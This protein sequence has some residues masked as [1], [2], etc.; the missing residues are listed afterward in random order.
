M[1]FYQVKTLYIEVTHACNQHCRHCYLDGGIHR[2]IAEMSFEQIK[3]LLYQFKIQGGSYII[4]TGGEPLART[5]IFD[6]LDYIEELAIPFTFASNALALSDARLNKLSTYACLK[7]FFTSILGSDP[8]KHQSITGKDS[9][10]KVIHALVY[11]EKKNI[12][13]YVQVTLANEYINDMDEIAETLLKYHDCTVKFTPIASLGV[14]SEESKAMNQELVVPKENFLLFHHRVT[15]L[16]SKYPDR[17]DNGNLLNYQQISETI[18]EYKNDLLYSLRYQ[19]IAVRPNGDISFSC[20]MMNPY[21]FG[22]AY[23]NIRIPID[24][25]LLDYI[26]CLRNAESAAL[27]DAE[28]AVIEFDVVVDQY[29]LEQTL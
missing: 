3:N 8:A 13:V 7:T 17:I 25:K 20:N 10:D 22:K 26:H 6:I 11:F 19:F 16:Q 21:V 1:E 15:A 12:P 5:D 14:K 29:I 18:D 2:P 24:Q 28:N 27:H 4:I 9:Y 23:E